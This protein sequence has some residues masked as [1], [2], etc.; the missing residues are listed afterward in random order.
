MRIKGSN[1][2][3]II[4]EE[5]SRMNEARDF[6]GKS[7]SYITRTQSA[8]RDYERMAAH[9]SAK[10][11]YMDRMRRGLE[12][13]L[14]GGQAKRNV[15]I[16]FYGDVM[17]EGLSLFNRKAEQMIGMYGSCS[18]RIDTNDGIKGEYEVSVAPGGREDGFLASVSIA[19]SDTVT[20]T[21]HG[22]TPFEAVENALGEAMTYAESEREPGGEQF[23]RSFDDMD[24]DL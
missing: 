9:R 22:D 13:G 14:G 18:G 12:R 19:P 24:E 3:K 17:P 7:G 20:G 8:D 6:E 23:A 15:G 5:I 2:K 1:L 4:K 10:A 21:S 11:D 16:A